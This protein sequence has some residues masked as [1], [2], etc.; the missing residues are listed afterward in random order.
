MAKSK[1]TKAQPKR[2]SQLKT[3]SALINYKGQ[4]EQA[5]KSMVL[6]H[7]P[8][9]LIREIVDVFVEKI[10]LE[11]AAALLYDQPTDAYI[12]TVSGGLK[13]FK[14]PEGYARLDPQ[15]P[16]IQLFITR[17][18]HLFGESGVITYQN[19][20]S[21]SKNSSLLNK[22]KGIKELLLGAKRQMEI[23][24]AKVCVPI[25]IQD[26]ELLGTLMLGE[27]NSGKAFTKEELNFFL[28]L[29]GDIAMAIK[30][31]QLFEELNRT[32]AE[33]RVAYKRLEESQ[34]A[35][36][37]TAKMAMG[38]SQLGSFSHEIINKIQPIETFLELL[39]SQG[40]KPSGD[41]ERLFET[42]S[43]SIEDIKA[44]FETISSYYIK[45]K[46]RKIELK[47]IGKVLEK[48]LAKQK[49]SFSKENISLKL[50]IAQ[51]LP[52]IEAKSIF[53]DLFYHLIINSYYGMSKR[54]QRNLEIKVS[55]IKDE[56]RPIEIRLTDTGGDLTK[57]IGVGRLNL[58]NLYSP[59][60]APL[61]GI[62]F[63]LAYLIAEDHHGTFDIQ[64]NKDIG[65]TFIIKLPLHQ[66]KENH[67]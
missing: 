52:Q 22:E 51:N 62:D 21:A 55:K 31:A 43:S 9:K 30:N 47:D 18:N 56:E 61:G 46:D 16:L 6:V 34:T 42:T 65:T 44:L 37:H 39:P 41:M 12:L 60:R 27:K 49:N 13:G 25:Y 7:E 4:L 59:E 29:S 14:I 3:P 54:K 11:H 66:P 45:I 32:Y 64:S 17:K 28:A 2:K 40:Y 33:L 23:Y 1:K 53:E 35:R 5:A 63:F 57:E 26:R 20:V 38:Y 58:S 48:V 24:R 50:D 19:F 10:K 15:S 67:G 8:E 36:I